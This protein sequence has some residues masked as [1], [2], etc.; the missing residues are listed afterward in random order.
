[1]TIEALILKFIFLVTD[2]RSIVTSFY[3]NPPRKSRKFY[4]NRS[5]QNMSSQHQDIDGFDLITF[6][7][8]QPSGIKV[9]YLPGGAYILDPASPHWMTLKK[10][11][12]DHHLT[13]SI[14][15][16]PKAP[17]HTFQ[18]THEVLLTAYQSH[19]LLPMCQLISK[20]PIF[21]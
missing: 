3:K 17:E 8:E 13:V 15:R 12:Q 21:M 16:Y 11:V 4:I 5:F 9:L 14:F 2:F 19:L 10:L 18:K 6:R 1:M 7:P 20:S